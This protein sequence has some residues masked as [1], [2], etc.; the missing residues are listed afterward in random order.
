MRIGLFIPTPYRNYDKVQSAIW[1]RALQIIEPLKSMGAI[2]SINNPFCYYDAVIYHRGMRK[3]SYWLIRFL[4]LIS[5]RVYWDTC[6][7]YFYEHEASSYEQ[8]F[9]ARKIST[10]VDGII[11]P[12][13]GIAKS[14]KQFNKNIFIMPDPVDPKLSFRKKKINFHEPIIG[15]SGVSVKAFPL[16]LFCKFLDNRTLIISE[17]KPY[18]NFNYSFKKW[19]FTTFSKD[20]LCIDIAFLPRILNSSYTMNNTSFKALVFAIL[21]IPIIAHRLPSYEKLSK[22]YDGIVFLEDFNN[23]PWKAIEELKKRSFNPSKV[24]N[25]YSIQTQSRRLLNWLK[26][27]AP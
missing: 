26:L 25:K 4:R 6:V 12:T 20:L 18:V 15:W 13:D 22:Y 2:V 7:D 24:L 8:V 5:K 9:Y 14:A 27:N 23:N 1:I 11:V 10:Y 17:K 21:G 19:S 3:K 16:N